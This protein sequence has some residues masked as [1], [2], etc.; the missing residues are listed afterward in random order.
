[1]NKQLIP[2]KHGIQPAKHSYFCLAH[3]GMLQYQFTVLILGNLQLT[4]DI[5]SSPPF[6]ETRD[7]W[8]IYRQLASILGSNVLLSP[9]QI[10]LAL[11]QFI[12]IV[13]VDYL[14]F[15][16]WDQCRPITATLFSIY[17]TDIC[18]MLLQYVNVGKHLEVQLGSEPHVRQR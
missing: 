15:K 4:E 14:A 5:V 12:R 11:S 3:S 1:M 18:S 9:L 7:F 16:T 2:Q 17:H 13:Y 10:S 6:R 8:M